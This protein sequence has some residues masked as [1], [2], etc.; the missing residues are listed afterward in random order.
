MFMQ[1]YSGDVE[2]EFVDEIH[3]S[4]SQLQHFAREAQAIGDYQLAALY[5]QEVSK[6]CT[7]NRV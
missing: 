7:L 1:I 2:G 5:Y 6:S 4:S 3:P